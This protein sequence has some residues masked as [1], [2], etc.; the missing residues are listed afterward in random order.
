[1]GKKCYALRIASVMARDEGWLAEHMLILKLIS[2]ENKAYY[3]AAAFPSACGKTNLAMLQPT[4]PAGAPRPSV[5]TSPG[6][7]LA[8]RPALRGQPRVRV[9]RRRAGY[10]LELQPERDEDDRRRQH[11]LHQRRADRRG[12]RLV[13]GLEG[14]PQHLIDWKGQ[15]WTRIPTSPPPTRTRG[16]APRCR[17]AP[18]WPRSGTTRRSVPISAILFGGRRKTTVP[19]VTQAR[20]WQHGV[21]IGATLGSEKTAAAEGKVGTIRRDPMAMLPFLGYNAGDCASIGSISGRTPTSR[22]CR[23]SSSSTG[24]AAAT[25]AASCGRASV[26]TAAC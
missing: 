7:G 10:Q 8:G 2:P 21:F 5:T 15:D 22:S 4:I 14:E 1:L 24:S 13:E 19:L 9:L 3:I 23:R 25:T 6:C 16:T 26:R 18:R 20:D 17:S 11:G 12:R